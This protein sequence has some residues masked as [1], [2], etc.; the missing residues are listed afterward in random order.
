MRCGVVARPNPIDA[1]VGG[2]IRLRRTLLGMTQEKLGEALGLTFQQVQKYERGLNRIG[3]GRLYRLGQILDVPVSFFFDDM[4]EGLHY[5]LPATDTP[6]AA[7]G[8]NIDAEAFARRETIELIRSYYRIPDLAL[9]RRVFELVKSVAGP[10]PV[11]KRRGRPP[12]SGKKRPIQ[13]T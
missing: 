13:V 12:G 4:P 3:S 2:R 11:R 10:D 8:D 1:H 7:H 6:S 5:K 9:R